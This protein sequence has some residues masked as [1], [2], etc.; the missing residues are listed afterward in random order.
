MAEIG[1]IVGVYNAGRYIRRC[2]ESIAAQTFSDFE[3]VLVDDGSTDD[4]G[5][6][7]D[8]FCREDSR[9]H[10]IHQENRGPGASRNTGL[11][12]AFEQSSCRWIAIVDDDDYIHPLYLEALY[13]AA[14]QWGTDIAITGY[15]RTDGEE[16]PAVPG[17]TSEK[18]ETAGFYR[19]NP[20]IASVLW[21]KLIRKTLFS[22][23]F[24]PEDKIHEDEFV[25]YRILF[26]RD[27]IAFVKEALYAYFNN[28]DG[29]MLSEWTMGKLDLLEAWDQQIVF[30][31]EKG[32]YD[33]VK[34]KYW[35]LLQ[36]T[37]YARLLVMES[38]GI[39]GQEKEREIRILKKRTGEMLAHPPKHAVLS[40]RQ[41]A[42]L[43]RLSMA[44]KAQMRRSRKNGA[45]EEKGSGRIRKYLRDI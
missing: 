3:V 17:W 10:V 40:P 6:I 31:Q 4:S 18:H 41:Y 22:G 5:E 39:S 21:G 33:I 20:V 25:I 43:A 36:H 42:R 23:I 15:L 44:V 1:I 16:L 30:F 32:L 45:G 7:C 37:I 24:F 26:E 28:K 35:Y 11:R 29:I 14:D 13:R 12:W 9:F 19:E 34:K 8:D 38:E 27:C 2:L